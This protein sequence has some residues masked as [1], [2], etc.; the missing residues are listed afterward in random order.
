V[1]ISFPLQLQQEKLVA[2][3]NILRFTLDIR[4]ERYVGHHANL[5]FDLDRN[6]KRENKFWQKFPSYK[7]S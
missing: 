1:G 4:I 7:I 3:M 2:P 5:L 6:S